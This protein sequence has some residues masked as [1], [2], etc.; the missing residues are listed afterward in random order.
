MPTY[1]SALEV[2]KINPRPRLGIVE[3]HGGQLVLD[4]DNGPGQLT[5]LH[6]IELEI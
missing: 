2:V 5:T 3:D 4:G 6:G 1:V